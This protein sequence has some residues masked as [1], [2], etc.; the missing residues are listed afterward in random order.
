MNRRRWGEEDEGGTCHS[1]AEMIAVIF[2]NVFNEVDSVLEAQVGRSPFF[3]S[4]W[5]IWRD[6]RQ[7]GGENGTHRRGEQECSGCHI[8]LLPE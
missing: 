3:L 7:R 8:F 5:W 4:S 6:M 1:D 2:A